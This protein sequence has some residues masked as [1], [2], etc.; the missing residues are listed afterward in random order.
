[1]PIPAFTTTL[2]KT[3]I[4]MCRANI[5]GHTDSKY[6]LQS[7]IYEVVIQE[8]TFTISLPNFL[9]SDLFYCFTSNDFHGNT[10]CTPFCLI[11]LSTVKN[12]RQKKKKEYIF[13]KSAVW[14]RLCRNEFSSMLQK[15]RLFHDHQM[16]SRF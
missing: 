4:E 15:R 7:S 2:Q 6:F 14:R 10:K 16:Q 8:W 1:M 12:A 5:H 3:H 11:Y 9:F 13:V